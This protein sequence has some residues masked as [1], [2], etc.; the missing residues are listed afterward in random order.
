ML[1]RNNKFDPFDVSRDLLRKREKKIKTPV[2]RSYT[3]KVHTD[4]NTH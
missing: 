1:P 4:T 2:I 3:M